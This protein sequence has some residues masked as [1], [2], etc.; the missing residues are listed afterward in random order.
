M[1]VLRPLRP[2]GDQINRGLIKTIAWSPYVRDGKARHLAWERRFE[3]VRN[4]G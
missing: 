1:D 4:R 2:P 3:A